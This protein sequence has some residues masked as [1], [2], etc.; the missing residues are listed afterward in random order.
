[1]ELRISRLEKQL[2]EKEDVISSQLNLIQDLE[3]KVKEYEN[4]DYEDDF[5]NWYINIA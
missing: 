4:D 1:M 5:E 3:E 2:R